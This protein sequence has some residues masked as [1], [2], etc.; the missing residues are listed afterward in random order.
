MQDQAHNPPSTATWDWDKRLHR[1]FAVLWLVLSLS[2]VFWFSGFC[3][4]PVCLCCFL[5]R[6]C[7]FLA[8]CALRRRLHFYFFLLCSVF[9]VAAYPIGG[10]EKSTE[11]HS[12]MPLPAPW[13][14]VVKEEKK[15]SEK[16]FILKSESLGIDP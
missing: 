6:S 14:V 10:R 15:V 3:K 1:L 7:F 11:L 4:C 5:L 16:F 2:S 13:K 9:L 12:N 8:D